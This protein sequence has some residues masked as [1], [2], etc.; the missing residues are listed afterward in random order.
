MTE[1]K[2]YGGRILAL[3]FLLALF[4]SGMALAEE[5]ERAEAKAKKAEKT[6][7]AQKENR[8]RV[9]TVLKDQR[10][11]DQIKFQ[12]EDAKKALMETMAG[13]PENKKAVEKAVKNLANALAKQIHQDLADRGKKAAHMKQRGKE[14]EK[15]EQKYG[16]RHDRG[17]REHRPQA[18]P[19]REAIMRR[20]AER[21][22]HG[23][24]PQQALRQRGH[25]QRGQQG[26]GK[27]RALAQ[28]QHQGKRGRVD[29]GT[30][31]GQGKKG[32]GALAQIG[33][34]AQG[35]R[36]RGQRGQQFAQNRTQ[37]RGPQV[38]ERMRGAQRGAQGRVSPPVR[39]DSGVFSGRRGFGGGQALAGIGRNLGPQARE[40]IKDR[41]QNRARRG[42]GQRGEGLRA[43][44]QRGKQGFAK[45][46]KRAGS[47]LQQLSPEQKRKVA[48]HLIQRRA[49]EGRGG[50]GPTQGEYR[51]GGR[52]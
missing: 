41:L 45:Y 25:S 10:Q 51:K 13:D 11:R 26:P 8:E 44:P 28:G 12:V 38:N 29:T 14:A 39:F 5:G 32:R 6:E 30:Q 17:D 50:R 36:N 21:R 35:A 18:G 22:G 1:R 19:E 48:Q 2:H 33:A 9:A 31:F 52:R 43:G 37:A 3:A 20:L 42:Q 4:L 24:G 40:Y 16:K 46:A 15:R 7:A 47:R 34:K 49:A 23:D 27:G